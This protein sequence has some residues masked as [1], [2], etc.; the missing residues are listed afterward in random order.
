M[1]LT[2]LD[3]SAA[4]DTIDHP[5]LLQRLEVENVP[6]GETLDWFRSY[7]MERPQ[8]AMVGCAVPFSTALSLTAKQTAPVVPNTGG[9]LSFHPPNNQAWYTLSLGHSALLRVYFY[10]K[11]LSVLF[12]MTYF[13]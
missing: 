1:L 2:W 9:G 4:F 6:T 7:V 13:Q 5:V 11:I 12:S 10:R 8:H 3:P